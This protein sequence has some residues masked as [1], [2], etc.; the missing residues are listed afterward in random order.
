MS[1]ACLG[2]MMPFIYKRRKSGGHLLLRGVPCRPVCIAIADGYTAPIHRHNQ[3]PSACLHA[4]LYKTPRFFLNFSY[5]LSR[6]CLGKMIV[7]IYLWYQLL[8]RG[9]FSHP[10]ARRQ[11]ASTAAAA[12]ISRSAPTQTEIARRHNKNICRLAKLAPRAGKEHKYLPRIPIV[13]RG[14]VPDR[15]KKAHL[16]LSAFPTDRYVCSEPVLAK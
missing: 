5:V 6:A 7:C 16:F 12:D 13:H 14:D 3:P 1:R 11:R 15:W 2:K 8:E 9:V 4:S 10:I